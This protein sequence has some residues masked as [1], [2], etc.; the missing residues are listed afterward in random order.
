[1]RIRPGYVLRQVMDMYVVVGVGSE[2]YRPNQI[3]SLNET[4]AALWRKLEQGADTQTL[5][6][7]L[8]EEFEV[9]P[10]TAGNDLN[11][12]LT[13]LREHALIDE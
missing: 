5:I 8:T 3:M 2:T 11:A 9:D 1:M 12:F 13:Q 7:S 6:R 4:G 10:V